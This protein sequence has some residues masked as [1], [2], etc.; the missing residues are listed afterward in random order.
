MIGFSTAISVGFVLGVFIV[1]VWASRLPSKQ[2]IVI[3][4]LTQMRD[5]DPT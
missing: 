1:A 3:A 5:K 4:Q 2:S